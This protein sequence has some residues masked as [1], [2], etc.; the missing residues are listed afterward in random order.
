MFRFFLSGALALLPFSASAQTRVFL[1]QIQG[2]AEA[3][4]LAGQTVRTSGTVSAV[5]PGLNGFY[6]QDAGGDGDPKTS[7]GA[8]VYL[9]A[10]GFAAW[11]TFAVGD[12]VEVTGRVEEYHGQT[13]ISGVKALSIQGKGDA[14]KPIALSFPLSVARRE[15]FEGMLVQIPTPL[16]VTDSHELKRYGTLG[17]SSGG[18]LFVPTNATDVPVDQSAREVLLDDGSSKTNPKPI[19]FLDELNTR[20]AG[21]QVDGL[22]GILSF[23]FGQFRLLP[24][25]PP[26]FKANPRP[27]KAPVVGGNIKI[28]SAN[29]HNYWTTLRS[30]QN[31]DAR[32][33]STPEQFAFQS[34]KIVAELKGLDADAVALMELENNGDGAL[35]DLVTRLNEAYGKAEYAK[36]PLPAT[37][38][39]DDK[40][41]VGMIYKPAKLKCVG[42]PTSATDAIFERFPLAQTFAPVQGEGMFTL[43]AN[44][45]KSKGS[46]PDAGDVDLGEGAW[47]QKRVEQ[48]KATLAFVRSLAQPNVL[49]VGDFNAYAEE[50]PLKTLRAAGMKHL[51]LRLAP[52]ERYSFAYDGRFGSLDHAF[53]SVALDKRVLGFA[54]WHVNADEPEFELEQAAG[55][56]FRASD[57]DPFLVGINLATPPQTP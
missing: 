35:D 45:W 11:P 6:L 20:R 47:N 39:G 42:A 7:D 27:L 16:F 41:R 54:E 1:P 15:A 3:S 26:A 32:G 48:A 34:A 22:V 46:A 2:F 36:V 57:H 13:Q 31:H 24:T 17:L 33:A 12:R 9:T 10:R 43:V 8:F 25:Q 55:T 56:P 44:H 28:A 38:L 19:P 30:A 21:S 23:D 14:I 4:P 52:Q 50:D 18:R 40:I 29:L 49:L 53:A 51:N 37:G 5:F